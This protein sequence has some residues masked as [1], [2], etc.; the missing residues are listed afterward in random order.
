M[1]DAAVNSGQPFGPPLFSSS[2]IEPI[3]AGTAGPALGTV[4]LELV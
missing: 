4:D 3:G 1:R 2:I